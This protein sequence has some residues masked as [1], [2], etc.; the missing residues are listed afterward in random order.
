MPPSGPRAET[1]D[2]WRKFV[3][4]DY[5]ELLESLDFGRHFTWAQ[6]TKL[7]DEQGRVYTD[8]LAGFGVHNAGHNHPRL[9]QRLCDELNACGPSMLNVDAPLPAARLAERLS[10]M[11][12]PSLCRT[13][14]ASGGAEAVEAAIKIA[15][16]AT[17]RNV[18]VSCHGCWHGLSTGALALMD[19]ADHRRG[20]GPLLADVVHIPFGDVAALEATCA[21]HRP[22]AFFVEPI[23]G[24][25]GIRV[26]PA[27]YLHDAAEICRKANCLLVIDEIQTGLGRTGQDFATAFAE[28]VPDVLLVGKALSGGLVPV[29]ACMTTAQVWSGALAGPERCNLCAS[30][31]GG[32]R[33]AMTAGLAMLDVLAEERLADR[34]R[35]M[36]DVL[37]EGLRSLASRHPMIRQVRGQGL[38]AAIEFELPSGWLAAV[39]PRRAREQLF[40]Q[41]LAAVLLRDHG[42]LMQ[43]CGLAPNVLRIEPPLVIT[44]QEIEEMLAALDQVLAA[45]PSFGSATWSAFRKTALGMGL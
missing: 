11:T 29:A 10:G 8:F 28:A 13:V 16:A 35:E 14:F 5:V 6:G 33:L 32:G 25:G 3:N 40:A 34:A 18:L 23:Q 31:F 1:H 38:L 9:R 19:D 41:V 24:E 36:G 42:L 30:T 45:Y 17:G 43:T 7:R 12:H 20:F 37:G 21:R 26:P 22:A 27:S 39:V 4:P 15:R 44:R 2:L